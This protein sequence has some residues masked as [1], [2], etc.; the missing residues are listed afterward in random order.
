MV[1]INEPSEDPLLKLLTG[2]VKEFVSDTRFPQSYLEWFACGNL[3]TRLIKESDSGSRDVAA[4]TSVLFARTGRPLAASVAF[5]PTYSR[6]PPISPTE[7]Q[8]RGS[9]LLSGALGAEES[10]EI[11]TSYVLLRHAEEMDLC[12]TVIGQSLR[13]PD[14]WNGALAALENIG[15]YFREF[16]LQV[17][18]LRR[19][20]RCA[21]C[22]R[23]PYPP[24]FLTKTEFVRAFTMLYWPTSRYN[25]DQIQRAISDTLSE[26]P[27]HG[28]VD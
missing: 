22:V 17:E 12:A 20:C 28:R 6:N 14:P 16:L 27:V 13:L 2:H 10:A 11:T 26:N 9:S 24:V 8:S 25:K 3:A 5:Y 4:V 18:F 23:S 15:A 21:H 19:I 7:E 1:G